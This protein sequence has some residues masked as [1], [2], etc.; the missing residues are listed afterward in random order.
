MTAGAVIARYMKKKKWRLTAH[1]IFG[2]LGAFQVWAG[3]FAATVMVSRSGGGHL[4]I[5]HAWLGM[6][7]ALLALAAPLTG[8]MQLTLRNRLPRLRIIHPWIGRLTLAFLILNAAIGLL[9]AT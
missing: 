1:R 6:L 4:G 5:P 7:I 2:I 3:I 8:Q 9:L